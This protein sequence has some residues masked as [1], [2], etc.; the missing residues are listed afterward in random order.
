MII[1]LLQNLS[2]TFI[3]VLCH[4]L[5]YIKILLHVSMLKNGL[6]NLNV[7]EKDV[8]MNPVMVHL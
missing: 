6:L 8:Q 4:N 5:Y 7:V 3:F 1:H 2:S